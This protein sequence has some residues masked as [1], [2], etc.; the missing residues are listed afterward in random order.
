[1]IYGMSA[2][3]NKCYSFYIFHQMLLKTPQYLVMSYFIYLLFIYMLGGD[4]KK[5]TALASLCPHYYVMFHSHK[6]CLSVRKTECSTGIISWRNH[7]DHLTD[8]LDYLCSVS[9][10]YWSRKHD[11]LLLLKL[12]QRIVIFYFL[13]LSRWLKLKHQTKQQTQVRKY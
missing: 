5:P 7:C 2:V 11:Q 4:V 8:L 10:A 9:M 13:L 12:N 3:I 6:F 1:M